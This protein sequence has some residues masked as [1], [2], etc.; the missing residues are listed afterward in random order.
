ME[1]PLGSRLLRTGKPA[2]PEDLVLKR[3]LELH[4][5]Q[6]ACP[7]E[8]RRSPEKHLFKLV[9]SRGSFVLR[10][11]R[12]PHL[13]EAL[14]RSELLW[15]RSLCHE[16]GIGVPE[17]LTTEGGSLTS[18]VSASRRPKFRA[19][20]R[21]LPGVDAA[22][23]KTLPWISALVRWVPGE[24]RMGA[25]LRS[26]HMRA[27]GLHIASLHEHA[28][29]YAPPEGF[30]RPSWTWEWAFGDSALVWGGLMPSG[31]DRGSLQTAAARIRDDLRSLDTKVTY[32][33]SFTGT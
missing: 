16:A 23:E 11:Y 27:L 28:E 26:S 19:L 25:A 31:A 6:D 20:L 12:P 15:M 3:N 30:V 24:H 8:L 13:G 9:S 21:R 5:L 2:P 10:M 18:Q 7:V 32:S 1:S 17:P 14:L 22:P 4:T 33:A 29:R